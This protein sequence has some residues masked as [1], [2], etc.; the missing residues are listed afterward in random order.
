MSD[1]KPLAEGLRELRQRY[2]N[3]AKEYANDCDYAEAQVANGFAADLQP[4]IQQAEAR[5]AALVAAGDASY[6]AVQGA[7]PILQRYLQVANEENIP[8]VR[9]AL[10][11]MREALAA[12][13]AAKGGRT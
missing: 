4:F 1:P 9:R 7:I 8:E 5:E 2:W 10:V 13:Q 12:W 11:Q 3:Y 6:D